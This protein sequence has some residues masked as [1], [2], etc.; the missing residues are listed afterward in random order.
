MRTTMNRLGSLLLGC[1]LAVAGVAHGQSEPTPLPGLKGPVTVFTPATSIPSVVATNEL[2]AAF[3]QG[4]LHARDRFFQMD[5]NRRAAS[6]TLAELV[7]SAA[8]SSDIQLRTLGIRRSAWESYAASSSSTRAVL[9]AYANGV[10]AWLSSNPLP[11]EYGAL[12]LSAADPWN[13]VDSIAIGNVAQFQ[14]S[15][16]LEEV[17]FTVNIGTYQGV[18]EVVGFDGTALFF[19]DTHRPAPPDDRVTL[20][21]F[22]QS[23]G[24]LGKAEAK[25]LS[26]NFPRLDDSRIELARNLSEQ[27][28]SNPI[29]GPLMRKERDVGSN[30]WLLSGDVTDTGFPIIA[31]DPHL[32]LDT[33]SFWYTMHLNVSNEEQGTVLNTAGT[34]IAGI[35]SIVLGCNDTVCWGWTVNP[36]DEMDFFFEDLRFNNLGLP[37][38]TVHNGEA[39]PMILIYQSYFVNQFDGEFDNLTRAN[40]GIDGGAITFVVPRR[41]NGPIVDLVGSQ[42]ISLQYTGWGATLGAEFIIEQTKA[43]DVPDYQEIS[44]KFDFGSQNMAIADVFGNIG[45]VTPAEIPVRTDLQTL[46]QPDGGIPPMFIRDGTGAL[47]H[48]WLPVQNPQPNQSTPFE[49]LPANETANAL[50]PDR[51]YIANANNDPVGVSLDNNTLNQVRPGGGLY[52][53]SQGYYSSYRMGRIDRELQDAIAQGPVSVDQVKALQANNQML[54][55]E[56]VLPHLLNAFDRATASDAWPGIAQFAA[57]PRVQTS[58]G[59]FATWDF[60][61]PTGIPEGYDPGENPFGLSP[62]SQT[63]IDNSVAATVF[64]TW[65]GQVIRNTIDATLSAIGLGDNL[66]PSTQAYN[67]LKHHLDNFAT[68][69]G[70]GASGINFFTNPEAPSAEDARD[71][72]LLASLVAALDMLASDEFAPAFGNSTDVMDY[73]W[74]KLHRIVFDHPLND[75]FSLPNGLYGLSTVAGLE[76][77]ARHGGYQVV[78]ASNHSARADG[79]NDFMFGSGASRRFVG[80]M[81]PNGTVYEMVIA[82]GQ[83]GVIGS[84]LYANQLYVWLV[85]GYLPLLTN[86]AIVAAISENVQTFGPPN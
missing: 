23:I 2:D 10:N 81:D 4:Y 66:P 34:S 45:Y 61:T 52:Y 51:G 53:I 76:G 28:H 37:T 60:S 35:P 14:L 42:G 67:A 77:V 62:P 22:I 15:A 44:S 20:P 18:G 82:G 56:L 68:N 19:E 57:D 73:R 40:V 7:G 33:P 30:W 84:P 49:I 75:V 24:G 48:D 5:F 3:M 79:L 54:D 36:I 55:A 85:N 6:G 47:M 63:E 26:A 21:G 78:D 39:E 70:V 80:S 46:N 58:M 1:T 65:R 72:V 16:D 74:G 13:P 41:S 69:Q 32:S 59:L 31:N 71:F 50:N 12:E 27:Y 17:D 29:L 43:V 8:L 9:Q 38:H 64:S 86:P 25:S 11:P 83:S